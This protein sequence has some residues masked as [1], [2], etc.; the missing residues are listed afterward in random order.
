MLTYHRM[1][2][3][4]VPA[5]AAASAALLCLTALPSLADLTLHGTEMAGIGKAAPVSQAVTLYLKGT[6]ARLEVSGEPATIQDGKANT[7]YGLNTAQKT[8]YV[9]VPTEIEPGAGSPASEDVH[10]D[11]KSTG[12]TLTFAGQPAH[13]YTVTGT[14]THPRPEG[15]FG[16]RGGGGGR[17]RGGR[18]GGG[19]PLLL[20]A[21]AGQT[22]GQNGGDDGDDQGRSEGGR[23]GEGS[24]QGRRVTPAQWSMTGEIWL[25]DAVKFP[26]KETTRLMAQLAGAA[27]GP[28]QQP[29]AD[30]LDKHHGVPLL[31][32]ITVDYIPASAEGRRINQY[33]GVVEGEPAS[34]A[35]VT[36]FTTLTVQSLSEAP[37]SEALFQAP[38]NYTLVAAPLN[39]YVPGTPATTPAP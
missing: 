21:T 1:Y 3:I 6:N 15:G 25:A 32:R 27:S 2:H 35:P 23:G 4:R 7:L 5:V 12:R 31:A 36:T 38:L 24:G 17:R 9:T 26:S 18:G 22:V 20:P 28:F 29:L 14:V 39:P 13:Q 8:Y 37:L 19:F 16:R 33:G 10:L 30:A 11:L 34:A